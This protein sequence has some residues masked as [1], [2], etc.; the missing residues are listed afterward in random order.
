MRVTQHAYGKAADKI[1]IT[2]AAFI[3]ELAAFTRNDC[4]RRPSVR[5]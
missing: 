1:E 4:E 3:D 2:P 5:V